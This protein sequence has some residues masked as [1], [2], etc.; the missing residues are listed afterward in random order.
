MVDRHASPKRRDEPQIPDWID[1]ALEGA[2]ARR[3]AAADAAALRAPAR[4]R[5]ELAP[6]AAREAVHERKGARAAAGVANRRLL[7]LAASLLLLFGLV[8]AYSASTAQAYFTYG[9]S[10]YFLKKQLLYAAVGIA[11]MLCLARIDYALLRKLAWPLAAGVAFLLVLVLVPGVGTVAN[12][13][14][15][16]IDIGGQTV[17]PSEFAKLAAV[18]LAAAL[19]LQRPRQLRRFGRF[20]V[21]AGAAIV[22]FAL[23]IM[24][25]KDLSTTVILITGVVAVLLV[26]GARWRHLLVVGASIP[27]V[28]G[29]LILAEPYRQARLVS[30]LDPWKDAASS[31]FQ[32]TQ[33]LISVASGHLFGVGL[34]DSVQKFGFLPEQN[35]DMITGIIG[36]E[37]G[38]VGLAVLMALYVLLA[39]AGLRIALSCKDPFGKY[40]AVGVTAVISIQALLNLGAALGLL[41]ILGVPLPLVSC[42]GTSLL[43]VLAGI[44]ILLNIATNRRSFISVTADRR[45]R[46]DSGGGNGRPHGARPRGR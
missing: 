42:G 25:G 3:A 11:V 34:G 37:L 5:H 29:L 12:G 41:P 13:A 43:T 40:V 33:A 27:V 45:T 4:P 38:L 20:A 32:A 24:L 39:W 16:W 6:K 8:M 36:E 14:R 15:R 31:G 18:I 9:S 2:V 46:A 21:V 35:T 7:L 23:L 28:V 26:A 17:Q 19:A 44:G 1:G 22:P 10:Y 30:F